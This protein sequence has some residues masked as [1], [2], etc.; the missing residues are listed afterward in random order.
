[1]RKTPFLASIQ[2]VEKIL[3]PKDEIHGIRSFRSMYKKL[4]RS[5]LEIRLIDPLFYPSK[6]RN[7]FKFLKR[8]NHGTK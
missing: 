4:F 8:R 3:Q 5:R 7:D 1:M 6:D 2:H